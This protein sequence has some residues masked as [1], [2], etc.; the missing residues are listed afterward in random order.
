M[1]D[2]ALFVLFGLI[3]IVS[4]VLAVASRHLVHAALWLVVTLGAVAGAFLLLGA[5]LLAWVQVLVYVGAVVVLIVFALMLT[6]RPTGETSAEVT[7]NQ[8]PAAVIAVVA[9]LGLAAAFVFA[10]AGE[11]ID[12]QRPGTAENI[13]AAIFTHWVLAFE[14]LSVVLLVAL[15]AA[16]VIS[17]GTEPDRGAGGSR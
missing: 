5:E 15:I 1:I 8:R 7:A 6:R 11:R 9:S 13:G 3:A 10:F 4:G 17:R 12:I 14:V 2:D 16:I